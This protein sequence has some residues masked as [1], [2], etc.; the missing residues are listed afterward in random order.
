MCCTGI[1]QLECVVHGLY[2]CHVLYRD[3]TIAMCYTGVYNCHVLYRDCT[4]VVLYSDYNF[5]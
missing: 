3:C 5:F 4:T 1:V 2:N